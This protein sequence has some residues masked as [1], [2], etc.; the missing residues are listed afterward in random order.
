MAFQGGTAGIRYDGEVESEACGLNLMDFS[1]P[2]RSSS[3]SVD[4]GGVITIVQSYAVSRVVRR[5]S[6]TSAP[7]TLKQFECIRERPGLGSPSIPNGSHRLKLTEVG[8]VDEVAEERPK[9][10]LR[11][12]SGIAQE[13]AGEPRL[14]N[15]AR[16][17]RQ[18]FCVTLPKYNVENSGGAAGKVLDCKFHLP[19]LR[20][21]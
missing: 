21:R 18:G 19:V 12:G 13:A 17:G 1:G 16:G 8:V 3:R 2:T 20:T 11:Q 15:A 14:S 4:D 5:C 7:E 6:I 10:F 9:G